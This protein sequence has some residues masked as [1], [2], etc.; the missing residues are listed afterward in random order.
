MLIK[1]PIGVAIAGLYLA[2]VIGSLVDY[3][4]SQPVVMMEFSLLIL[5]AP[6]S[7]LLTVALGSA[8]VLT[9]EN[10]KSLIYPLVLFAGFVN[11]LILYYATVFVM[12]VL[13][14]PSE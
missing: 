13:N 4:V 14:H 3:S 7:F 6:W 11:A 2:V 5:T 1:S 8:N 12:K 10:S 9:D